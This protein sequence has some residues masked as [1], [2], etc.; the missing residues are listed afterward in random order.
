MAP[1]TQKTTATKT[2]TKKTT[3]EKT[4]T[5]NRQSKITTPK[6]N[7]RRKTYSTEAACCLDEFKLLLR[8]RTGSLSFSADVSKNIPIYVCSELESKALNDEEF[9]KDLQAE[10]AR[11]LLHGPGVFV[12]KG[13]FAD[14]AA[15][16]EASAVFYDIIEQERNSK[17]VGGD[18]FAKAGANSRIWNSL[19]KVCM[20]NPAAF[21]KYHSNPWMHFVS[22]GWLGPMYQVSEQVNV[23][24]PGGQAQNPHRKRGCILHPRCG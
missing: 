6:M 8:Q 13:A 16:D 17:G 4:A 15:L 5:P 18:H 1:S 3:A 11:V 19:E 7:P 20:Q 21:A 14:H 2:T 10:W 24:R 12:L 23:I 9:R 22:E